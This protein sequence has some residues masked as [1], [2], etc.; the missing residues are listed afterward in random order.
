MALVLSNPSLEAAG[1]SKNSTAN[2]CDKNS[3]SYQESSGTAVVGRAPVCPSLSQEIWAT[4][5][6]FVPDLDLWVTCRQV[7]RTLRVEAEREFRDIRLYPVLKYNFDLQVKNSICEVL[8]SIS[9]YG[10]R[11]FNPSGDR[12]RYG[13]EIEC[14][15]KAALTK[16]YVTAIQYAMRF[17]MV[18][19]QRTLILDFVVSPGCLEYSQ[20]A[21]LD[22]TYTHLEIPDLEY[23]F[24]DSS[25]PE[26]AMHEVSFNWR[27]FAN[28]FFERDLIARSLVK[29]MP[30]FFGSDRDP[31]EDLR[32]E[33]QALLDQGRPIITNDQYQLYEER[34]PTGMDIELYFLV[35]LKQLKRAFAKMGRSLDLE[36]ESP[37]TDPFAGGDGITLK[38]VDL[39]REIV[40]RR[41]AE[42]NAGRLRNMLLCNGYKPNPLGKG[43]NK[44]WVKWPH[45]P[46]AGCCRQSKNPNHCRCNP[47]I[48]SEKCPLCA[49][50]NGRRTCFEEV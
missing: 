25:P 15:N 48:Q 45:H 24:D 36:Q 44:D 40:K 7:S 39:I 14:K 30:D 34:L 21:R 5:L 41:L 17:P 18:N 46:N 26:E 10:W 29:R 1:S 12:V 23:H 35:Y 8:L 20:S 13:V 47:A 19:F 37:V 38:N 49:P 50:G 32:Q 28:R 27:A 4:I 6:S 3:T 16:S 43:K 42:Q 33:F 2:T 31:W 9:G 11:S 22:D